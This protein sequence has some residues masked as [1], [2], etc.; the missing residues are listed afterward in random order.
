MLFFFIFTVV[1]KRFRIYNFLYTQQIIIFY[2]RKETN[3]EQFFIFHLSPF[4]IGAQAELYA[5][6]APCELCLLLNILVHKT[7]IF[8]NAFYNIILFFQD[9]MLWLLKFSIS[10]SRLNGFGNIEEIRPVIVRLN[11]VPE[12]LLCTRQIFPSGRNRE[13]RCRSATEYGGRSHTRLL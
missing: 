9:S 11:L 3:H 7:K 12:S 13:F 2:Q 6:R 1:K 4:I 5:Y 8:I 10:V